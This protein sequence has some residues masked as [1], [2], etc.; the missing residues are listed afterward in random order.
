MIFVATK[1]GRKKK[2][3]SPSSDAVVGSGTW[4]GYKSGSGINITDLEH[5]VKAGVFF[6]IIS[7]F[8]GLGAQAVG[9]PGVAGPARV[10]KRPGAMPP[11]ALFSQVS[12]NTVL[13]NY[14]LI[15]NAVKHGLPVSGTEP[16]P[17]TVILMVLY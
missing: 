16:L 7:Y 12:R 14:K 10:P 11:F 17:H 9:A 4:D 1:N 2:E 6:I 3:C 5:W 15:E 8:S 13:D